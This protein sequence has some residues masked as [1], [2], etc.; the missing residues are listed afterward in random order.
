MNPEILFNPFFLGL[1]LGLF[2][3][4]LALWRVLTLKLELRRF[5]NHLSDRIELE[6]DSVRKVKVELEAIRRENENLRIQVASAI[7]TPEGR[8]QRDLEI[9]A[10]A[11]KRMLGGAPGFAPVWEN[12]KNAAHAELQEEE[13][14]RSLPRRVFTRLFGSPAAPRESEALPASGSGEG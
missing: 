5:R 1:G 11:E 3:A 12:A 4:V 6:A 7:G 8:L 2:C 13:A 14:G 10:R 9:Y